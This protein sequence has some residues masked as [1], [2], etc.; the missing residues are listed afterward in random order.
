MITERKG[1]TWT[2]KERKK[3]IHERYLNDIVRNYHL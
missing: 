3:N 2:E 1:K